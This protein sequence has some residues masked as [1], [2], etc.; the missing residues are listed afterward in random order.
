LTAPPAPDRIETVD[1]DGLNLTIEQVVAVARY[2]ARVRLA[3]AARRR[4]RFARDVVERLVD[5]RA[6]VYGLTTGFGSKRDTLIGRDELEQL[7][8]NLIRSHACGVGPA[9]AE[10]QVRAATLLRANTLAR[11]NSGVRIEVVEALVAFLNR[12]VYPWIPSRGSLGASGDLAPLSHLALALCNDP[13]ARFYHR[14]EDEPPAVS[15]VD[16]GRQPDFVAQP[17]PWRFGL[18][19]P[20]LFEGA[21][22]LEPV[23]LRAKEGL[24]LNN[25]TQVS[26]AIG[27]LNAFDSTV[28]LES[29]EL[30]AGLSLEANKAVRDA[31]D[32][33]LH[34]ARPIGG[35][36]ATA[37]RIR[38]YTEGSEIFT[39]P[40]NTA[41][42]HRAERALAAAAERLSGGD[43]PDQARMA[44]T[45]GE[46]LREFEERAIERFQERHRAI[47][48]SEREALTEGELAIRIYRELLAEPRSRVVS[49][50]AAVLDT[51][52][53]TEAAASRDFLADALTQLQLALPESPAVQDDYSFRCTPQVLGAV[54][55]VIEDV[56]ETL[57]REANSA[58]DN[59]LI[60]PPG[61]EAFGGEP[62]E[63]AATLT[64]RTC[65][66]SVVSGGNFHG[67]PLALGLD[68]LA[69]ALSELANISERRTAHLVDGNLSNGLPSLL[70]ERS[71]LNNGLMIPQYVAAALVSENK[72][73]CHPASVDSIPTCENTEDHVSMSPIAAL[74]C[75]QVLRNAETVVAIELLTAWQ[76]VWFRRPLRCGAV[77]EILWREMSEAGM[78]P[79][80]TDRVLYLDME[81]A[82]SFLKSGRVWALTRRAPPPVVN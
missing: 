29:A 28:L 73:L 56:R 17:V 22:A 3:E 74:K 76:G 6:K 68:A 26:T 10:D 53:G 82:R 35:Q 9:L 63:Y 47:P 13:G 80:R 21:S 61:G 59:P 75:E 11:G 70:V 81:W 4:I 62:G 46:D 20:G 60:F 7:Q 79:V 43:S 71:G 16:G 55:K 64:V 50:Y 1:I 15:P 25:G 14:G 52:L 65:R 34:D 32:P 5:S 24:A 30:V 45:A 66:E 77:T 42:I 8:L 38:R 78:Q 67:E 27:I 49:L 69:I 39:V 48:E 33:R 44:R 37:E 58:T 36:R 23:V 51:P 41:R 2:R 72:I 12:D 57:E 18:P 40:I 31:F 19:V 54:R